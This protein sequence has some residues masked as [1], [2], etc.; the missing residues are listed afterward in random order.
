MLG[1][2]SISVLL[3]WISCIAATLFC[4][5]YGIVKWNKE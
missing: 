3:A 5:I 1:F 4:V 2:A